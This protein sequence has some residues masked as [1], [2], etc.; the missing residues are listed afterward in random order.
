MAAEVVVVAAVVVIEHLAAGAGPIGG[1]DGLQGKGGALG[2]EPFS[3]PLG[4]L[5][6]PGGILHAVN[7]HQLAHPLLQGALDL[8]GRGPLHLAPEAGGDAAAAHLGTFGLQPDLIGPLQGGQVGGE[9]VFVVLAAGLGR[10]AEGAEAAAA[11][12]GTAL[13][14]QHRHAS[15][16]QGQQ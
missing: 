12:M 14:I 5:R 13:Q 6:Q 7:R 16:P 1:G 10:Q 9:E 3:D 4:G 8:Q 11:V 15:L 2:A